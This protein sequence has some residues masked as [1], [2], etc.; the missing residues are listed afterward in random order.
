V[1]PAADVIGNPDR[2][3]EWQGRHHRQWRPSRRAASR[4]VAM[5]CPAEATRMPADLDDV[6]R[7]IDAAAPAPAKRGPYKPRQPQPAPIS[8]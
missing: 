2:R 6:A 1:A 3:R 4:S 8:N 5:R 7:L